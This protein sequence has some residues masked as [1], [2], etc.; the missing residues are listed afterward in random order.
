MRRAKKVRNKKKKKRKG[1]TILSMISWEEE[2]SSAKTTF[3]ACV[4]Y[5][6]YYLEQHRTAG[7]R[8]KCL[9]HTDICFYC[10]LPGAAAVVVVATAASANE[11]LEKR[12][13]GEKNYLHDTCFVIERMKRKAISCCVYEREE[14]HG[15]EKQRFAENE[16]RRHFRQPSISAFTHI[17][18]FEL[19]SNF[20]ESISGSCASHY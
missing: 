6:E 17:Q 19:Y 16:K 20:R 15:L 8:R 4:F 14:I 18:S 2:A 9:S 3:V 13:Q 7:E 5:R 10:L 12:W 11:R 1:K